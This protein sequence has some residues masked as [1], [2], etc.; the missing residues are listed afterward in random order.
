MAD[1]YSSEEQEIL[2]L[3]RSFSYSL[4]GKEAR[5]KMVSIYSNFLSIL[6]NS[7]FNFYENTE[8][9]GNGEVVRVLNDFKRESQSATSKSEQMISMTNQASSAKAQVEYLNSKMPKTQKTIAMSI[10]T[11]QNENLTDNKGEALILSFTALS[12]D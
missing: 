4:T 10:S 9:G 12:S 7:P 5:P 11:D 1:S 2:D 8:N 3:N 6:Q